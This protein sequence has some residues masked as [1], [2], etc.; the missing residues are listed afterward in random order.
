MITIG[1][2]KKKIKS[3]WDADDY[4]EARLFIIEST[5]EEILKEK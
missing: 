5:I 3:A 4:M 2:F 1:E